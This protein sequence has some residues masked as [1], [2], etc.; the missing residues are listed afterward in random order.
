MIDDCCNSYGMYKISIG[1]VINH[2]NLDKNKIQHG[3]EILPLLPSP[4]G[5]DLHLLTFQLYLVLLPSPHGTDLH[6]L[7]FQPYFV[8]FPTLKSFQRLK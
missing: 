3:L 4:H 8:D 2:L 5:T 1:P 6:L 7:T